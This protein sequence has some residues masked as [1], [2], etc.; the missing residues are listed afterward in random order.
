[1]RSISIALVVLVVCAINAAAQQN[2]LQPEVP[3]IV[4]AATDT[5]TQLPERARLMVSHS[6]ESKRAK[7][8]SAKLAGVM[9]AVRDAATA[10]GITGPALS[11]MGYGVDQKIDDDGNA[12]GYIAS[13]T[14]A[15]DVENLDLIGALI[16]ASLAAGASSVSGVQFLVRDSNAAREQAMRGAIRHAR[17]EAELLATAAGCRLLRP[18]SI[19]TDQYAGS[20]TLQ[21]TITVTGASPNVRTMIPSREVA[22]SVSV[23]V[24]WLLDPAC[25]MTP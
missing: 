9:N 3:K 25:R 1:M 23:Q 16:D 6:A 7:D 15:I 10:L 18:M 4:T 21:E 11:S 5:V 24:Q 19:T 20:G 8:A 13:Q 14:I 12:K 22:V 17:E 2:A